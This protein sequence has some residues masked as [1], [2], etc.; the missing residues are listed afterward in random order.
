M[1]KPIVETHVVS[2]ECGEQIKI[3]EHITITI[4][5]LGEGRVRLGLRT[6]QHTTVDLPHAPAGTADDNSH[7][8]KQGYPEK[9]C[10]N[11][12]PLFDVF[13]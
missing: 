5:S 13:A 6:P 2:S 4:L 8:E 3:G 9:V 11:V 10:E 7:S 1:P 12:E